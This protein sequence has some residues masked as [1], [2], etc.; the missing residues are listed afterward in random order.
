MLFYLI[1]L[2]FARFLTED[3]HKLKWTSAIFKSLVLWMLGNIL[4]FYEGTTS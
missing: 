1:I 4:T 2:N 3:A